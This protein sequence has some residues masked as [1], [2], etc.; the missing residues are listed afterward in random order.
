MMAGMTCIPIPLFF[1]R[2]Q[3]KHIIED[4]GIDAIICRHQSLSMLQSGQHN[5]TVS[6]LSSDSN[7]LYL[8]RITQTRPQK[9]LSDIAKITYTSGTTGAPKGVCLSHDTL[10]KVCNA[11]AETSQANAKDRCMIL[12]PL[13]VLLENL[14]AVYVPLMVGAEI[15]CLSAPQLGMQAIYLTDSAALGRQIIRRRP[16]AVIATP[17]LLAVLVS[18][19]R[20]IPGILSS[21]RFIALGGAHTPAALLDAAESLGLPVYQGYG[22]SEAGSVVSMNRPEDN[23]TGSVGKPLQHVRLAIADDGEIIIHGK[24][25]SGYLHHSDKAHD[26]W[27]TGDL[28][29]LDDD[30]YLYVT[31]RK[32]NLIVTSQGRNISPEWI[33]RELCL[34][35]NILQAAILGDGK[36]FITAI[37]TARPGAAAHDLDS[38]INRVNQK[39]P[40]YAC[41][42]QYLVRTTPFTIESGEIT[43]AGDP[44]RDVIARHHAHEL[45]EIYK[46][47][48]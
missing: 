18:M 34:Q 2:Q 20:N 16:T 43:P 22:L 13:S 9:P 26:T 35:D 14:A 6:K 21:L 23:R 7:D 25:F 31:G 1:S 4:A 46:E 30:G 19:E 48:I 37:L 41:I 24:L 38:V 47:A 40:G 27:A 33:E 10:H 5:P 36:P 11:L 17:H 39:L 15:I 29:Y 3:I 32:N 12:L 28:G 42:R 8:V 44:R 45:N